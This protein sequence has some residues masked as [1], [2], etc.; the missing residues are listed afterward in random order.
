MRRTSLALILATLAA[1]ALAS[2]AP[3][4]GMQAVSSAT[5]I[6][7]RSIDV[8]AQGQT[9]T[10][11]GVQAINDATAAAIIGALETR[12]AGQGVEF[13][14]GDVRSERVSLRDMALH[15]AGEIR[16]GQGT[17]IPI[18]FDALYDS[19]T[20]L[21]ESPA[22]VLGGSATAS[23]A[24]ALPLDGLQAELAKRMSVEF[25]SQAVAFDLDH[26]SIVGGDGR[27]VIVNGNGIA[28]FDQEDLAPVQVQAVYDRASK[29]W[30]DASYEFTMTDNSEFVAS[31]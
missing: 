2:K 29:R 1:T 11:H 30:I 18:Q 15:G 26:T 9:T 10:A 22:I 12:F 16:F 24:S 23:S 3:N 7:G 25:A 21:V 13:R 4:T 31:S 19:G 8:S 27:R 6:E 28:R 5:R 17:W 14:M 20:Q